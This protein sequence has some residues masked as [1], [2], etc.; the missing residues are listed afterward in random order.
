MNKLK[1]TSVADAFVHE[2]D[3]L[4]AYHARATNAFRGS[5]TESG[6]ISLLNE[7]VFLFAAISFEAALSDLYFAYVNKDSTL[8]I[9]AKEQQIRDSVAENFGAWYASRI[10]IPRSKHIKADEL[11]P[12][13]DPR[14]YNITFQ[15]TRRMIAQARKNLLPEHSAKYRAIT[16]AQR[17]LADCVKCVRNY[18]AHRSDSGFDSMT[19][20][21]DGLSTG[22][23]TSLSRSASRRVNS[24]GAYLK[25]RASTGTRTELFLREMKLFV[26]TI[27]R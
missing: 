13:L 4:L 8:F 16:P 22:P 1:P 26:N 3:V 17:K 18:I 9:S 12:L 24:V 19:S 2:I 6:D 27:G 7:Q 25:S 21:L 11:Y 15:N 20:A 10:S 14:G 23:Y 5:A